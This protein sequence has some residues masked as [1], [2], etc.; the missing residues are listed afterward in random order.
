MSKY[1]VTVQ[2]VVDDAEDLVDN[3]GDPDGLESPDTREETIENA[4]ENAFEDICIDGITVNFGG[5]KIQTETS[6]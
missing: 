1:A 6:V 2:V 3:Y 4:I 5:I